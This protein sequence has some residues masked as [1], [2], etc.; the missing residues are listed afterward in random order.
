MGIFNSKATIYRGASVNADVE[1]ND[2][3]GECKKGTTVNVV[4]LCNDFYLIRTMDGTKFEDD[5][6]TGFVEKNTLMFKQQKLKSKKSM[7]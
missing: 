3:K 4:A 6:D 2:N 5:K 7:C 1:N